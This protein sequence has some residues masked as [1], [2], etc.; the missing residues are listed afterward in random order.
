[1]FRSIGSVGDWNA[2]RRMSMTVEGWDATEGRRITTS[3]LLQATLA[4]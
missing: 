3:V 2:S 4:R 1:M